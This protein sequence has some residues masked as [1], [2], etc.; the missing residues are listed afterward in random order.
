MS[1]AG[2]ESVLGTRRT[3]LLALCFLSL[4]S[5]IGFGL[6]G[7]MGQTFGAWVPDPGV[8]LLLG[9]VARTRPNGL[10]SAAFA[11]AAGR[12]AVGIDPPFAVLTGYLAI[13]GVHAAL[14]RF[15][16]GNRTLVRLMGGALY[17]AALVVWFIAVHE[18]SSHVALGLLERAPGFA[19]QTGIT[20]ALVAAGLSPALSLIPGFREWRER[21]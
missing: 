17:S 6:A 11:V 19:I 20:T 18:S 16:D 14:C 2:I 12:I 15:A 8:V 9:L 13:A 1:A 10:W 21:A 3:P 7:L 4:W 5:A